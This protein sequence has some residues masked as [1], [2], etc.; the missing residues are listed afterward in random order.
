[1]K[2]GIY[3]A[4]WEQVW[5]AD[6]KYYVEKVAKLGFDV[7][8]IGS[9]P[10]P[11]YSDQEIKELK[12]CVD[13][14][15]IM[16]TA[17]YGPTFN[18]NAGSGD[19]KIR[20]EAHEWY[21]H[22]FETMAKLDIHL[23]GGAL[24]SYWPMDFTNVNKEEDWKYSVEGM[25][26]LAPAA[27]EYDIN[28]GMEVLNRFENHILNTAEEGVAFV[29]EVG[30][31]N[32]KVMLDTFHMNIEETSIGGAIRCAGD[33][34]GHVH[35]GEC[36]RMVPGRGRI[37]WKEIGEALHDVGYDGTVVMEPFIRMGGQ[38]GSDIKVWRD[39]SRGATEEQLDAEAKS[40][41]EFQRYMLD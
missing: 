11:D 36:N 13:D 20:K 27:A 15:G 28:L 5:A 31:D 38:V 10:L 23:I 1:M 26:L 37:P 40:A 7:L 4:F 17:G 25:Q 3:Y 41:V 35:T 30:M 14:H 34:L 32:V 8:E 12:K 19:P 39:I 6:Y 24:Y 16:L 2:H 22:L 18:H 9:G 33:L 29:R 21:K